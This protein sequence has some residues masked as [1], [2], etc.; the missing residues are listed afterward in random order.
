LNKFHWIQCLSTNKWLKLSVSSRKEIKTRKYQH[1][2]IQQTVHELHRCIDIKQ[3]TLVPFLLTGESRTPMTESWFSLKNRHVAARIF[4]MVKRLCEIAD[5]LTCTY[6]FLIA[7][8]L[9]C[10]FWRFL[11][12]LFSPLNAQ[13]IY[14]SLVEI[15]KMKHNAEVD[16][17]CLQSFVISVSLQC[18]VKAKLVIVK[19]RSNTFGRLR[20][21]VKPSSSLQHG[22]NSSS[23]SRYCIVVYEHHYQLSTSGRRRMVGSADRRIFLTLVQY[24]VHVCVPGTCNSY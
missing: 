4:E 23:W 13:Q 19:R 9:Q 8:H 7:S 15:Q 22:S 3:R 1:F 21:E 6:S 11:T 12:I 2:E 24:Q 5:S 17:V 20:Y 16:P 18:D 14:A 10:G